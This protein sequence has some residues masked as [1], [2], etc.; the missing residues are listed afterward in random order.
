[1][2]RES[3]PFM[4][5]AIS[6]E[7]QRRRSDQRNPRSRGV[8]GATSAAGIR[9]TRAAGIGHPRLPA[10]RRKRLA[11]GAVADSGIA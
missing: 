6:A 3:C 7:Q 4:P 2:E 1:M 8:R 5:D 10:R 11:G 9:H